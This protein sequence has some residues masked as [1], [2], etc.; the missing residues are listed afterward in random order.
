MIE[1]MRELL[2]SG[3]MCV[4]ATC[5]HSRPHCSLMAY[6]PDPGADRVYLVTLKNTQKYQNL[7][8][9]STVSLLVDT[10]A[11]AA[12]HRE[13]IQALT[14]SGTCTPVSEEARKEAIR[15]QFLSKHPHLQGLLNDPD[16]ALLCVE[17]D[18]FLL[19]LGAVDSHFVKL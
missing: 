3:D 18:S 8:A 4:L 17:I 14:V 16:V 6:I 1:R 2:K 12:G 10:R 9:N 7:Q 13:S 5:A 15:T 19:L 11:E